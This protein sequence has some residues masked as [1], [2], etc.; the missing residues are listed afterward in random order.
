MF[1]F[2][3]EITAQPWL[4]PHTHTHTHTTLENRL[5]ST[6]IKANAVI[7]VKQVQKQRRELLPTTIRV[8]SKPR[9]TDFLYT[10]LGRFPKPTNVSRFFCCCGTLKKKKKELTSRHTKKHNLSH[11]SEVNLTCFSAYYVKKKHSTF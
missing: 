7:P 2:S 5:M 8:N 6:E 11:P 10:W 4:R 1:S 9:F 3:P